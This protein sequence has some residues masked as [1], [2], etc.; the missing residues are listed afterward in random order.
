MKYYRAI[1]PFKAISFDLDDTLYDNHSIIIKAN[2]AIIEHLNQTYPEL[3]ELTE[4]QWS[5]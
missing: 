3:A 1:K 2:Q 5:L 4:K